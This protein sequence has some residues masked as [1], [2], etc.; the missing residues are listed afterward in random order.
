MLFR[1]TARVLPRSTPTAV[2]RAVVPVGPVLL[3]LAL[4]LAGVGSEAITGRP[5]GEPFVLDP[6]AGAL[7]GLFG[8]PLVAAIIGF[9][10]FWAAVGVRWLIPERGLRAAD[11]EAAWIFGTSAGLAALLVSTWTGLSGLAWMVENQRI[12]QTDRDGWVGLAAVVLMMVACWLSLVS[13]LLLL[14]RE[15]GTSRAG[16]DRYFPVVV[17]A[18]AAAVAGTA[19]VVDAQ[20]ALPA[21]WRWVDY[22]CAWTLLA[23]CATALLVEATDRASRAWV[24]GAGIIIVLLAA[25]GSVLGLLFLR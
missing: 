22:L 25:A 24:F 3:L 2:L 10:L 12:S 16:P 5:T 11:F 4:A 23:A 19:V 15:I 21:G 1:A 13:W 8:V 18:L 7:T 17:G 9:V 14:D 20:G 6:G